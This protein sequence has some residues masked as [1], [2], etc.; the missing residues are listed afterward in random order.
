MA[1]RKYTIRR[2]LDTLRATL[3]AERTEDEVRE[4]QREEERVRREGGMR[5]ER[6][7]GKSRGRGEEKME[8]RLRRRGKK[9]EGEGDCV[10]VL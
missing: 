9:R 2:P 3:A 5:R 10:C 8:R 6:G 7:R 1:T 4:K